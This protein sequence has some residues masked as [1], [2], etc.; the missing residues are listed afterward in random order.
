MLNA[1]LCP[2]LLL[3]AVSAFPAEP[4][5]VVKAG[6]LIDGMGGS[7]VRNAVIVIEGERI[8]A[9]GPGLGIPPGARLIDLSDSTVLPGFIDAHT[10]ISAPLVGTPGWADAPVRETPADAVLRGARHARET[11]EAGYTTIRE[12]G[13]RAFTDVALR[14]AILKGNVPG[15]RMQ[16][17]AHAVGITGGHCDE[18][19]FVPNLSRSACHP[20]TAPGTVTD[21]AP[22]RGI[23]AT[24]LAASDSGVR[25][26]G[27]QPDAFRPWSFAAFAS[28]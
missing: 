15:P 22:S 9:V 14:D 2:L 3:L 21:A 26:V 19:G 20:A 25:P 28:Q 18:S 5:T 8:K 10:H 23:V 4:V 1:R 7:P 24:P 13:A 17:A 11:L 27:A 16:V 6:V 12:V